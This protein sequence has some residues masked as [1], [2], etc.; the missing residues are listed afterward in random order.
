MATADQL[1]TVALAWRNAAM[2]ELGA[3]EGQRV[4][5]E[6]EKLL[7]PWAEDTKIL[8]DADAVLRQAG[9]RFG[10][11]QSLH[12]QLTSSWY[13]VTTQR[14]AI[15]NLGG[16]AF[17]SMADLTQA[18]EAA[19]A[20]VVAIEAG[21]APMPDFSDLEL[22]PETIEAEAIRL[23]AAPEE[24]ELLV[25]SMWRRLSTVMARARVQRETAQIR[26]MAILQ[27]LEESRLAN[28]V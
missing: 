28:C 18:L 10:S 1:E 4:A 24:A 11:A 2:E 23:G 21:E 14:G 26:Q 19:V 3:R 13:R 12:R 9:L 15:A 20:E 17:G 6:L 25:A 22:T 16:G 5:L 7:A 27:L 8:A